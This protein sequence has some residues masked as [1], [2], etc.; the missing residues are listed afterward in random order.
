MVVQFQR[1]LPR[2]VRSFTVLLVLGVATLGMA[3]AWQ[4]S[5]LPDCPMHQAAAS[6]SPC[7][8]RADMDHPV[9][10]SGESDNH[11][12]PS[13]AP[14]C[15]GKLCFDAPVDDL[16]FA[17]AVSSEAATALPPVLLLSELTS[18]AY[19]TGKYTF[20][21]P[22]EGSPIPIFLRTCVYLI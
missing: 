9:M 21:Y 12:S 8:E 16:L 20:D 17:A 15:E 22:P 4:T 7:C 14:C 13:P 3:G 1:I 18:P 2:L 11:S 5:C 10:P 19:S 6:S